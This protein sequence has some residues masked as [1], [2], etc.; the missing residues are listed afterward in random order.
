MSLKE[1]RGRGKK[2]FLFLVIQKE[3]IRREVNNCLQKRH[4][5]KYHNKGPYT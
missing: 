4:L 3:N 1:T 5:V 2:T